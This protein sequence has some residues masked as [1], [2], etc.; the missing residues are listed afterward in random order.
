MTLEPTIL[1]I[2]PDTFEYQTYS[3][4]DEQL[5]VQSEL[6]TVFSASTD[7]IEY[8]VYDQNKTLIYPLTTTPLL[9]YACGEE[10]N[11]TTH[12]SVLTLKSR[13]RGSYNLISTVGS[14]PSSVSNFILL[15]INVWF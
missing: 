12:N 1:P 10:S 3:N 15:A 4:S 11:S 14:I 5:I 9:A 8:Y 7:Y 13:G 2:N 6:D